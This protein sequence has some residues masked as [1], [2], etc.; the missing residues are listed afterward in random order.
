MF[1]LSQLSLLISCMISFE[2]KFEEGVSISPLG[3]S[4]L[5]VGDVTELR[6]KL[7][8]ANEGLRSCW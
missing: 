5:A 1:L 7:Y 8:Q 3:M 2:L 4:L 6:P